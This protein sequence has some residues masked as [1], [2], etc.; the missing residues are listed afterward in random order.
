M[1]Y[2]KKFVAENSCLDGGS[3]F[4]LAD[5]HRILLACEEIC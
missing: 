2:Y 3:P 1:V 5:G 4:F